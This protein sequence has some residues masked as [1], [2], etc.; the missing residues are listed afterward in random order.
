MFLM[1]LVHPQ[2]GPSG[3][4]TPEK[5][6]EDLEQFRMDFADAIKLADQFNGRYARFLTL[7]A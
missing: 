1:S 2:Y 3:P 4:I 7:P 6:E 5:V